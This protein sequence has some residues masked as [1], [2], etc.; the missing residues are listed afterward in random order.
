[1]AV[2]NKQTPTHTKGILTQQLKKAGP[3]L[4]RPCKRL[5]SA[6]SLCS[7]NWFPIGLT[8]L[9]TSLKRSEDPK[10]HSKHI[11]LMSHGSSTVACSWANSWTKTTNQCWS[12]RFYAMRQ[13]C[14]WRIYA[15]SMRLPLMDGSRGFGYFVRPRD[16]RKASYLLWGFCF[17]LFRGAM[18]FV[19]VPWTESPLKGVCL[20]A[21]ELQLAMFFLFRLETVQSSAHPAQC[22]CHTAEGW[23]LSTFSLSKK[24]AAEAARMIMSYIYY[25]ATWCTNV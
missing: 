19:S 7:H 1:M 9:G 13:Q 16:A 2:A 25:A 3:V 5:R 22:A 10:P 17:P 24:T 12:L 4:C 8:I 21:S 6:V 20:H 18:L 23:H 15:W 11:D 14:S